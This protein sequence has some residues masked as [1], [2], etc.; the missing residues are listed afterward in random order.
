MSHKIGDIVKIRQWEDMEKDKNFKQTS[1]D[2]VCPISVHFVPYMKKYCGKSFRILEIVGKEHYFVDTED[3]YKWSF[4]EYM[5]EK[6][7]FVPTHI[8]VN[9]GE[10][11]SSYT[12]MAIRLGA[13]NWKEDYNPP[14]G[15]VVTFITKNPDGPHCLVIDSNGDEI[16]IGIEGLK[17]TKKTFE[18]IVL[19]AVNGYYGSSPF[20]KFKTDKSEIITTTKEIKTMNVLERMADSSLNKELEAAG[21][22]GLPENIQE[23]L[24]EQLADEAKVAAKSAAKEIMTTFKAHDQS[25]EYLVKELRNIRKREQ[26]LKDEIEALNRAKAYGIETNNFIP[27]AIMTGNLYS[28][29]VDNKD[30]VSIPKDWKPVEKKAE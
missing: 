9:N 8:V 26:G 3:E 24:K 6:E 15:T 21:I 16:I 5:F 20:V 11:Y 10:T 28:H 19:K 1:R 13:K 23:A 12:D 14:N 25:V 22:A 4:S 2:L 7:E 17:E 29:Q 30:L 18:G 27:L